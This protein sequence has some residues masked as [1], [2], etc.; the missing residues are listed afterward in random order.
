[1]TEGLGQK[2]DVFSGLVYAN[3][4]GKKG[5]IYMKVRKIKILFVIL[6]WIFFLGTTGIFLTINGLD[7][8]KEKDTVDLPVTIQSIR[9]DKLS[10]KVS[11]IMIDTYEYDYP[12]RVPGEFD[13]CLPSNEFKQGNKVYL[14]IQKSDEEQLNKALFINAVGIYSDDEVFVSIDEYNQ[15]IHKSIVPT[16]I[17]AII[18][19]IGLFVGAVLMTKSLVKN[20]KANSRKEINQSL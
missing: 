17:T 12:F 3:T 5:K 7:K 8:V 20:K 9:L 11:Y 15:C 14:K 4:V 6:L 13:D 10:D 2:I 18:A 19:S 1:M 16:R